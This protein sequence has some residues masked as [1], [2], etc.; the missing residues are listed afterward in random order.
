MAV[1][2]LAPEDDK[3]RLVHDGGTVNASDHAI[4]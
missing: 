2:Q 4:L 3:L 1:L